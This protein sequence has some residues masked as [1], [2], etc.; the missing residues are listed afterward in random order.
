ME[1]D[2]TVIITTLIAAL[3]PTGGLVGLV[4]LRDKKTA[5]ILD[6]FDR[7]IKEWR[8]IAGDRQSRADELKTDLSKKEEKIN[9]MYKEISHYRTQIDD[10]STSNAVLKVL[11]CKLVGCGKRVPPLDMA[12]ADNSNGNGEETN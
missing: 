3:I 5:A 11:K 1:M 8:S 7:V 4:T 6:N 12:V 2:W 9:E 10:L